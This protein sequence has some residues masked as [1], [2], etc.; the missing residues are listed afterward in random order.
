MGAR[1]AAALAVAALPHAS[2][3]LQEEDL[4]QMLAGASGAL[5][6]AGCALAGGHTGEGAELALGEA[7]LG[8][9]AAVG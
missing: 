6:E 2:E 1:P 8:P 9:R 4:L 3:A 5:S 7:G